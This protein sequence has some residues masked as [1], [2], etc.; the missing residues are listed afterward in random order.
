MPPVKKEFFRIDGDQSTMVLVSVASSLPAVMFWGDR[1][2]DDADVSMLF[3]ALDQPLPHGGLDVAE[4]I[5][6]LPEAGRGF[7]DSP[8]LVLRRDAHLLYTQFEGLCATRRPSGWSFRLRDEQARL[9]ISLEISIDESS[10]VLSAHVGIYN[11]GSD[12]ISVDHCATMTLPIPRQLTERISIE[13]RWAAEFLPNRETIGRASWIQESRVG[14]TSHHAYPAITFAEPGTNAMIGEAWSAALAWSGNHRVLSQHCRLGGHQ[15][16]VSELLLPGEVT[17]ESGGYYRTPNLYLARTDSGLRNLALRWHR[18]VRNRIVARGSVRRSRQV[19]FNTW[20]ALYFQHTDERLRR[21]VDAAVIVGVERFI[22]DDGWFVGRHNDSAGLGDWTPCPVRYPNGLAPIAQYCADKGMQ[23]GLWVEPESVNANSELF[24]AHPDWILGDVAQPLGRNQFV[25]DFGREDVRDHLFK[26]LSSLL[27][28]APIAFIKW[29]MN[30]DMTNS[31]N[32]AGRA[33]ARAHV[34]G[35]YELMD[36]LRDA[37]PGLEIETCAS[38]GARADLGILE[39]SDRVWVSDCNDPIERQ[40]S[41]QGFLSYLPPELMGVHVG[42]SP[43]HTTSRSVSMRSRIL[44]AMFGH[45]GIEL[46]LTKI[47][48]KELQLLREGVVLYKRHRDWIHSGDVSAIDAPD[49]AISAF[50]A[51]AQDKNRALVTA[52]MRERS[53]DAL[54]APL[55]ISGLK[56]DA[57]YSLRLLPLWSTDLRLSKSVSRFHQ[58]QTLTLRGHELASA[59]IVLPPL[60]VGE[61]CV[62]EFEAVKN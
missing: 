27:Q 2:A 7:T 41:Q 39:R 60:A 37:F 29:D 15:C 38:G 5:T 21:L 6:W 47:D 10:D 20:E 17:L 53:R 62:I 57:R 36:R 33:G 50:L 23:F 34:L 45:F 19:H 46:D 24:R 58:G 16:Q 54:V 32:L 49:V 14:R 26:V 9:E 22:L 40:R 4:R 12:A 8:G 11:N 61:G 43:S 55:R 18:F 48:P 51:V 1:I 25:L 31:S 3:D 13:G 28:S 42:D 35:L 59:G 56:T 30:R 52:M 44:N